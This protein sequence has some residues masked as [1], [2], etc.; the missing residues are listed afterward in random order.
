M[1]EA[2]RAWVREIVTVLVLAGLVEMLLPAGE[3]RRFARVALGLFVVLA[4][5]RP[6]LALVGGGV[7]LD[8][9]LAALA[10]WGLGYAPAG[11]TPLERGAELREASR[12]RVLAAARAALE[13]Q[14]AALAN[15]DPEV[16]RAEAEVVLVS[17]PASPAY[18]S[19]EAVVLRVW[20]APGPGG[21]ETGESTPQGQ[22]G[23]GE[24]AGA[25]AGGSPGAGGAVTPI[26]VTV[27]PVIVGRD[28]QGGM[29]GEVPGGT[30][31]E[32]ASE[33]ASRLRSQLVLLFGV[34]P[35]GITVEVSASGGEGR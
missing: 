33:V 9:D 20:L 18:G 15:R 24:G 27:R 32:R 26:V 28:S 30:A 10:S 3:S 19:L 4:V 6:V 23:A 8:R 1:V 29:S 34:P 13:T 5:A 11:T 17:D 25:G 16:A 7:S 35:G 21:E 22:G 14:V 12:E 2:L 31:D